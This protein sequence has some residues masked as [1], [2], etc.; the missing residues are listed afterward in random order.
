MVEIGALTPFLISLLD[1]IS[2]IGLLKLAFSSCF[3]TVPRA[4]LLWI[5]CETLPSSIVI[6]RLIG[7]SFSHFSISRRSA[8]LPFSSIIV[9][10]LRATSL[11]LSWTTI[12]SLWDGCS[13][14][15]LAN[16]C[17]ERSSASMILGMPHHLA[18]S[19]AIKFSIHQATVP[20][21]TWPI[22]RDHFLFRLGELLW[23]YLLWKFLFPFQSWVFEMISS[24]EWRQPYSPN[25]T[26]HWLV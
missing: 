20:W 12:I 10:P 23:L 14:H 9:W 21:K 4:I 11:S 8:I 7:P 3:R 2:R 18:F 5:V 26:L 6:C 1:I 22:G 13:Y 19:I 25:W 24:R 17:L 15:Q 16:F